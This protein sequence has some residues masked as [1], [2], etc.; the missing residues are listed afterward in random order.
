MLWWLVPAIGY[1]ALL[2]TAGTNGLLAP[3]NLGLTFNS[4]LLHLLH[5]QF[6]VDP[7]AIGGEGYLHN[8]AVYAYFGIF[9]AL[10]RGLFLWLPDFALTDFTRLSC[11]T[12][13]TAMAGAKVASVRLMWRYGGA[14]AAG[15]VLMAMIA[16]I[17][18]GGAQIEFLRPS[19]YQEVEL[20]AGAESALF[21]YL[22]LRGLTTQEGFSPRLLR[23]MAFIAGL[24]LST[25]VPNATGLYAAF[26]LIWLWVAQ[27]TLKAG[28]SIFPLVEPIFIALAFVVVAGSINAARWGNPLVFVNLHDALINSQYPDRLA[29]LEQTGQ[30]SLGRL[31]DGLGYYFFPVQIFRDAAIGASLAPDAL[32]ACC[33]EL[34]PASFL[35]SDPLLIGLFVHGMV[36]ALR[37]GMPL[38]AP[39]FAAA[40]GFLV[41]T[42]L[43][44]TAFSMS[45]RYRMEFYPFFELFAFLG[46][47]ALAARPASRV[48]IFVV[49]GAVLSIITAHLMWLLYMLS[50]FGPA[51]DATGGLGVAA[52]Y[53]SVFQ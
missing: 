25:R 17:L 14:R 35:V 11:L 21:V 4:M 10:L 44:L 7:A 52:F 49:V 46:F 39:I 18:F 40:A 36:Q 38:R 31:V 32:G 20:W 50:P 23:L 51:A 53:R 6:D 47:G 5:G 8:G 34:P 3:V 27:R 15:L 28:G 12:A 29:L 9:P 22:V 48:P 33:A 30:F 37:R 42:F 16:A 13:V 2:L 45:F 24:C 41:P 19:I 1:Y 43:M 26:G